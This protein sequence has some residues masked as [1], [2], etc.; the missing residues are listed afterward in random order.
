M[1]KLMIMSRIQ[2]DEFMGENF[3]VYYLFCEMNRYRYSE[4]HTQ[5]YPNRKLKMVSKI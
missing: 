3:N 2:Q 4:S 1:I 5:C